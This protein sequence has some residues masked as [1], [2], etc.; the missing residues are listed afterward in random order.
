MRFR[1]KG[2]PCGMIG[3]CKFERKVGLMGKP[4]IYIAPSAVVVGE[5]TLGDQC[6]IWHGA[7][8]RGDEAPIS[9]GANTNVQDNAV[10]HVSPDHPT[11]IG[12]GVTIGHGAIVHGCT[13][14]DN[15]VIGM[16]AIVLDDAEIGKNCIVG[17]GALVTHG[18]RV[19]DGMVVLGSPAKP[20]WKMSEESIEDNRKNAEIYVGLAKEGLEARPLPEP[21]SAQGGDLTIRRACNEDIPGISKLLLQVCQVH[22]DGRPDLFQAGGTKYTAEELAVIIAD[23]ERP[24]FV[25]VDE[26]NDVLGYAFCVFEDYTNDTARTHVRTLYIDDICVDAAAR[27]RHVG[28]AV[29]DH[30]IAFAREQG[31]YNVTLNVWSCNPGAQR[32]YE[33]MGMTPYKVGMEQIL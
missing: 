23:D 30:V 14:G 7:V 32:F 1:V 29:Y 11:T 19:R 4:C 20:A 2:E 9:I 22:A 3:F 28:S 6:S 18:K 10:V 17:A 26:A 24:I 25:A 13:V 21:S 33:A 31:F 27:G 5:V 12:S 15:T 8:V 16:G